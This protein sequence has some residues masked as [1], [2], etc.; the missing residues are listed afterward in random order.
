M[1][2]GVAA[3]CATVSAL[4]SLKLFNFDLTM[5]AIIGLIM[6]IGAVLPSR[7]VQRPIFASRLNML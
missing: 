7:L 3:L 6:S 4:V 1:R 2:H 5:M